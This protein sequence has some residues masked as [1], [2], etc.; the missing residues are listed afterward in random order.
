MNEV[1]SVLTIKEYGKVKICL[2]EL[3]DEKEITRNSLAKRVDTNFE[4]IDKWCKGSVERMDL[5]LL[6][7][8][9]YV[10]GCE[11]ADIIRYEKNNTSAIIEVEAKVEDEK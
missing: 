4:V 11:P 7:R 3:L 5:D 6:A 8:I 1:D 10:L 2:K 9:C